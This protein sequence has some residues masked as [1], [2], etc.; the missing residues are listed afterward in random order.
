MAIT[1]GAPLIKGLI[2]YQKGLGVL[3]RQIPFGVALG[4]NRTAKTIQRDTVDRLLPSKF[5][6][7]TDWWTPGLKYGVN[8]FGATKQQWPNQFAIV[9]TKAPW[10]V[11]QEEGGSK[12]KPVG[13][14]LIPVPTTGLQPDK[15]QRI[16]HRYRFRTLTKTKSGGKFTLRNKRTDSPWILGVL[17]PTPGIFIRPT[18]HRLPIFRLYVG[19]TH[20][21]IKP[22]FGF[23]KNAAEIVARDLNRNMDTGIQFAIATA[24][25]K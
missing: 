12:P 22:R 1:L 15:R 11:L 8:Y 19:Y 6:L 2:E 14:D 4:L 5:I 3:S 9:N 24:K 18:K 20:V 21:T 17:S 23:Y 16:S 13:H 7:R 10:M 25:L